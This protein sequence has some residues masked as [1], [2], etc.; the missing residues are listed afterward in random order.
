MGSHLFRS[1]VTVNPEATIKVLTKNYLDK[2][3]DYLVTIVEGRQNIVWAL[4]RLCFRKETFFE[5][6]KVLMCF[7]VAEIEGWSDYTTNYGYPAKATNK[8]DIYIEEVFTDYN[9]INDDTCMQLELINQTLA[10]LQA[11]K[12]AE[13]K[14][15]NPIGFIKPKH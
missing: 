5:A 14:P 9:D 15:R 4:E 10:E 6:A 1:I 12:K 3:K 2:P 11:K 8:G 13:E 7:S